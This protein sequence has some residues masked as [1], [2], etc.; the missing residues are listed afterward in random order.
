MPAPTSVPASRSLSRRDL[1]TGR[2]PARARASR[3]AGGAGQLVVVFLRGG[4]DGLSA[5]L[6]PS[7]PLYHAAR[8]TIGVPESAALPLDATFGMHPALGPLHELY[9]SGR[10]AVVHACGNLGGSRSH[11]EAQDLVEQAVVTR[12]ADARGWITRHL[13]ATG[14]DALFG[15]VALSANVPGSLRGSTALSIPQIATFGLGGRSG[16]TS[17]WENTFR[18]AYA[19]DTPLDALGTD[20]LDALDAVA[21]IDGAGPSAT[22]FDDAVSLLSSGLGVRVVTI[23]TGGWDT[24]NA[25]GTV[26]AGAMT[27]LLSELASQ[28]AGFQ[29]ALDARGLSGVTTVVMSEFGRRVQQ[30]GSGGLDHGAAGVVLVMGGGVRGGRVLGSWPGLAADQLDRGD[31]RVTTDHRDVLWELLRDVLGNPSPGTVFDG[32]AHTPVGL[33]A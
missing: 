26:A 9:Q 12:R 1:L 20:V 11:F 17:T 2:T 6:P 7:D 27:D 18:A 10:L 25:M 30:N 16:V 4:M 24:H 32:H 13:S 33:F 23:D 29:S 15:A 5:V 8:P 3:A 21:G 28:L 14:N 22:A 19:G 31:L